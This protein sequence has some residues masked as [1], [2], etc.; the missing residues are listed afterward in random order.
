MVDAARLPRRAAASRA[1]A[2]GS[3]RCNDLSTVPGGMIDSYRAELG[4]VAADARRRGQ[5]ASTARRLLHRHPRAARALRREPIAVAADNR[6]R[7]RRPV[8][9]AGANDDR[10]RAIAELRGGTP[11][12]AYNAFIARIGAEVRE[13]DAPGGQREA[14]TD[15]VAD[16]RESVSGV[17]LDEEM[18]NL[19]RFQ[20]AYQASSRAMSTMDEMLDMLINRTGRVGL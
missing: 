17:S 14:L 12:D 18:S 19:V 11:D 1:P 20:R 15:A 2:A 7:A 3:A 16:R 8:G 9:G 4:T 5:R 10:A 13:A 6:H